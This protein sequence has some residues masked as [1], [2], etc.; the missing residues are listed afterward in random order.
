MTT[1]R[2]LQHSVSQ[3][4]LSLALAALITLGVLAGL[5]GLAHDDQVALFAHQAA[6]A[7]RASAM[8]QGQPRA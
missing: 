5:Q 8:L 3:Q 6:P 2:A 7:S 4:A 1:P